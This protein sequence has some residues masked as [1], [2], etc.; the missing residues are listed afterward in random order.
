MSATARRALAHHP[1]SGDEWRSLAA[2]SLAGGAIGRATV[3][4]GRLAV[5]VPLS[6]DI[7]V[8]LG[9]A[10]LMTGARRRGA[11]TLRRAVAIDPG[12]ASAIGNG[13]SAAIELGSDEEGMRLVRR[14][15]M[16]VPTQV[17]AHI[18]LGLIHQRRG[19][20]DLATQSFGLAL[21]LDVEAIAARVGLSRIARETGQGS[22]ARHLARSALALQPN[23]TE[24]LDAFGESVVAIGKLEE[25]I[26]AFRR[27]L[28]VEP[29]RQASVSNLLLCLSYSASTTS[30]SLFAAYQ[31]WARRRSLAEAKPWRPQ[32]PAGESKRRLRV[33]YLS[34]D[35][36]SHPV[37]YNVVGLIA[38]HDRQAVEV[39]C[40]AEE[41]RVDDVTRRLRRSAD[42][43][44]RLNGSSDAAV[45]EEIRRDGLDVLVLLAG[46]TGNRIGVVA[47][48][49]ADVQITFH[50]ISTTGL[51][52]V[53]YWI[54]DGILHPSDSEEGMT[55]RPLRLPSMMLHEPPADAPD[56]GPVP[57]SEAGIVRFGCFNNPVKLGPEV[58]RLW[59]EIL[60]R[61]P[62]SRLVLRY[63]RLTDDPATR[64]HLVQVLGNAGIAESRIEF[65][66][67]T[68]E[69]T[70]H[71][72]LYR[73]ID[74]ALDPFPFNG[75]TTTFEALWMGVPVV[76]LAGR[77][78]IGR[79]GA[80]M[81]PR[82]GLGDLVAATPGEYADRAVALA[83]EVGRRA[84][85]RTSLRPRLQ[86]SVLCDKVAYARS[87]EAA[88]RSVLAPAG[89]GKA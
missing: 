74:V 69:R 3:V 31:K 50:D 76:C 13:A 18:N 54:T 89:G 7:L 41:Q 58:A 40:Y 29:G 44:R 71:L 27:A 37:A 15:I 81:L 48:R 38:A 4:L 75:C 33:G 82:V 22:E 9:G 62:N 39:F 51:S 11:R 8:D 49:C 60:A 68:L 16:I 59:A 57:S 10:L 80:T 45:I 65:R 86:A 46:H 55:E 35:F 52:T 53:D 23:D 66:S 17:A 5:I 1:C 67:G 77:R 73:E 34:T 19:A 26:A 28:A 32:R 72:A 12:S 20:R 83:G 70:G 63:K 79:M 14:S 21:E 30:A 2:S 85:L 25:G 61:V 56:P 64:D 24:A 78:F 87:V 43:W 6:S 47:E 88:Y 36:Y 84:A 42:H